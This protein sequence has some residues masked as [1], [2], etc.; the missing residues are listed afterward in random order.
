MTG[1]RGIG[2]AICERLTDHSVSCV[3][4]STGHDINSWTDW[5]GDFYN[6]DVFINNAQDNWCQTELLTHMANRWRDQSTRTIVNIGS[7]MASYGKSHGDD[8]EFSQYRNQKRTL[9]DA[10]Q[11]LSQQC[12][13]RLI[14]INP[15]PTD[16]DLMREISVKKMPADCVAK[17]V[18]LAL[19]N[20]EIRRLD[21]W[22]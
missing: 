22:Q 10:F 21:I 2:Q 3:S 19:T 11:Q 18:Q 13:C 16:T 17:Y 12:Q 7:I 6:F 20:R 14:L 15:G 4:R 9:Q 1:C 8:R 5:I